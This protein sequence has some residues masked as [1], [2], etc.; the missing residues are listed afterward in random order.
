MRLENSRGK[1][2]F[3]FIMRW[4]YGKPGKSHSTKGV[5]VTSRRLT[6]EH[7]VLDAKAR[8]RKHTNP[9][10]FITEQEI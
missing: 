4:S 1:I 8:A 5:T 9:G 3:L 7:T 10:S 2:A 6:T